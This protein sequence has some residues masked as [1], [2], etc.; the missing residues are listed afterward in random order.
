MSTALATLTTSAPELVPGSPEFQETVTHLAREYQAGVAAMLA[1]LEAAE[2]AGLRI[3]EAYS[4][5]PTYS[6]FAPSLSYHGRGR[7][8]SETNN[9]EGRQRLVGAMKRDAWRVLADKLGVRNLMSVKAR[10]EFDKQLESGDLPDITPETLTGVIL[11]MVGSAR[12]YMEH[13]AR[14]VFDY[15]RPAHY[16]GR[17]EYKTNADYFRVGRKVILHAVQTGY[18]TPFRASYHREAQLTAVDNVFHL[19]AGCS[20]LRDGRP[21]LLAAI[22]KAGHDG[23]GETDLFA[24]RCFKNGNLH[25]TFKRLDLVK[26]L[27][28]VAAG[29]AVLGPDST[30]AV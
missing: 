14:E 15:L 11:G 20:I 17:S 1:G 22:E 16:H 8:H 21:P 28:R 2:L 5:G 3:R 30:E 23:K 25:L 24:F 27:N 7:S 29:D 6:A 18:G 10:E 26:E 19:L 12:T 9:A 4:G 13:A